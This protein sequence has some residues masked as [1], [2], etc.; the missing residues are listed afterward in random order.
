MK[1]LITL[2]AC[3]FAAVLAAAKEKK[4]PDITGSWKETARMGRDKAPI[5]YTDTMYT[6]FLIGN[7]YTTGRRTGFLYKG[8][9]K[10]TEGTLDLGMR[11]YIIAERSPSR[12]LLKDDG[13]YYVWQRYEKPDPHI[14]NSSAASSSSRGR[15]ETD[16]GGAPVSLA[17]LRG[18]WEVFKRTSSETLPEINYKIL[19]HTLDIRGAS[20]ADSSGVY[21]ASDPNRIPGW[22]ITRYDA[23]TIYCSGPTGNR[24]LKVLKCADGELIVE[25]GSVT[26]FFKQFRQ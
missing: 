9:Y 25:E 6:D 24:E 14:E 3:T 21:A 15:Q 22:Y 2:A 12:M 8:T 16:L 20:P 1:H 4:A 11:M 7:E 5:A 18:R 23:N 10:V 17:Q 26:Y 19:L 13:G